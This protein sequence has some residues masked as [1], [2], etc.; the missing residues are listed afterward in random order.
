LDLGV[1]LATEVGFTLAGTS[2]INN[3][4]KDKAEHPSGVWSLAPSLALGDVDIAKYLAIGE[5]NR[6]TLKFIK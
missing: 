3:N 5:S 2:N 1:K 6:M 4:T